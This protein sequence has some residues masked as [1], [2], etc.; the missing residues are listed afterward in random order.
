MTSRYCG[1][2]A[3]DKT[4]FFA[5]AAELGEGEV[6]GFGGGG[7]AVVV[8]SVRYF[9]AGQVGHQRLIFE[10][11]LQ[12]ALRNFRLVGRVGGVKFAA[13]QHVIDNGWDVMMICTRT[14]ERDQMLANILIGGRHFAQL[15]GGFHFGE[16]GGQVQF[17]ETMLG[18]DCLEQVVQRFHA[19]GLE[20]RIP[21]CGRN[22]DVGHG[23]PLTD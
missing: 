18:R 21:F 13:P 22:W 4:S 17:R 2:T 14:E 11:G 3:G 19:D 5:L 8:R 20:H 16:R 15:S 6:H 9:H 10:D 23:L 7:R 1:L 12:R